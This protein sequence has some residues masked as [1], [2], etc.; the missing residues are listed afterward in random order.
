MKYLL[1]VTWIVSGQ[2]PSIYQATFNS[3]EACE[4]ARKAVLAE[5]RRLAAEREQRGAAALGQQVGRLEALSAPAD[6]CR[7]IAA[8]QRPRAER[9]TSAFCS[10]W[11]RIG[12]SMGERCS[13]GFGVKAQRLRPRER[14]MMH[15]CMNDPQPEGHMA[16]TSDDENS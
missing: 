1:L 9:S 2:P 13:S 5:G 12:S 15:H 3:G 10:I 7:S 11:R 8:A 6:L 14:G 4:V 16:S